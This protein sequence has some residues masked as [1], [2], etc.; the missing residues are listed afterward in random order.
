MQYYLFHSSNNNVI[1]LQSAAASN[2]LRSRSPPCWFLFQSRRKKIST[3][4][5]SSGARTCDLLVRNVHVIHYMYT[6]TC[7]RIRTISTSRLSKDKLHIWTSNGPFKG[8]ILDK[9]LKN[10]RAK[11]APCT[12]TCQRTYMCVRFDTMFLIMKTM[13]KCLL[14]MWCVYDDWYHT[15]W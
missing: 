9:H 15:T 6:C 13:T 8:W 10:C 4:D 3:F 5:T 14:G 1:T 7:I 12:I 11:G 2:P